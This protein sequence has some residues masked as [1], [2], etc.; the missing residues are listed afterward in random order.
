MQSMSVK[1]RGILRELA[2]KQMELANSPQMSELRRDWRLHGAFS[3][4]SRPMI[5]IETPT[6]E[7]DILPP[8]MRCEG[9]EA[10]ALERELLLAVVN[11]TLFGDDTVVRDY[12]PV[13]PR[14]YMVPFGIE[15]RREQA[16]TGSLG[17]HFVPS[18][19]D[20]ERDF[21]KLGRSK[22]VL[23]WDSTRREL[24]LRNSVYGDILP[25][26]QAGFSLYCVLTQDIVHIMSMEDMFISMYDYPELFHR[27][28]AML[29][30]DYLAYFDLLEAENAL[31]P[32]AEDC[33]VGQ[34][35]YCYNEELPAQGGGLRTTDIWGYMDSQETTGVSPE[36]FAE[37]V[38]PYYR[39]VIRRYGLLSYGC[40]EAVD[41]IW[42]CFLSGL[43]NLRKL[44][45]SAW[46]DEAYIGERLRG[47]NIVYMRKPSPN[48][49]GV[50]S[51]LDERAVTDH[52]GQTVRAA[53]GCHLELVQRDVYSINN[54]PD[55]VRRYVELI[56]NCCE[57]HRH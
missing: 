7:Q 26:R 51:E 24:D 11:H 39:R 5:L 6:F 33:G 20:L 30:D 36:L 35:S 45:V 1:D 50:G 18:I 19:Q 57:Q 3:P 31:M 25:A 8:L 42:D 47:R 10:R 56:R 29:A 40:C 49:L 4:A 27:M 28:M 34:G 48:L 44:S 14:R 16:G 13:T 43:D 2:A 15:V 22:Y 21:H 38:A 54:T 52:I 12:M 46:A 23:D 17:H 37:F 55:K 41:P 9:E 53:E 32:T